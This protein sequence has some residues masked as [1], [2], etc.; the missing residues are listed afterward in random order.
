[1]EM[2]HGKCEQKDL[3][4]VLFANKEK[5]KETDANVQGLGSY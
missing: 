1:M 3:E 5:V 2:R 4:G